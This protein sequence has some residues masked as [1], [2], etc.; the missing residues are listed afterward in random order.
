[1]DI[2]RFIIFM[3]P[4]AQSDLKNWMEKLFMSNGFKVQIVSYEEIAASLGVVLHSQ[5]N[6]DKIMF[7]AQQLRFSDDQV[8]EIQPN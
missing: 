1:M 5:V 2:F 4:W 8:I 6:N 3:R 7:I